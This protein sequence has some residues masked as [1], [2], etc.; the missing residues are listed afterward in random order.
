MR[1]VL[2]T[3]LIFLVCFI[4][5][6]YLPNDPSAIAYT[7][8]EKV[9]LLA[10]LVVVWWYTLETYL[11]Q[12]AIKEQIDISVMPSLALSKNGIDKFELINIGNGTACNIKF[13]E[14]SISKVTIN[15]IKGFFE[16]KLTI[17]GALCLTKNEKT[18]VKV[19][20][21]INGKPTEIN[22]SAH[23]D[24]KYA[25]KQFSLYVYFED[26]LHRKYRQELSLGKEGPTIGKVFRNS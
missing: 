7:K 21:F 25:N 10:T 13:D 26:I 11:M 18:E 9:F 15:D 24:E 5:F 14:V 17:G 1:P 20:S 23:L 6:F 4:F 2:A 3:I 12:M 19:E 8:M 22:F 16:A